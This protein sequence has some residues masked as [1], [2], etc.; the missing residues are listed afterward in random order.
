MRAIVISELG[1][2]EV[3]EPKE[4]DDPSTPTTAAVSIP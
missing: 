4:I 1:G 2:P 3:L